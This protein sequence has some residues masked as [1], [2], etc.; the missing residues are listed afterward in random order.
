LAHGKQESAGEVNGKMTTSGKGRFE[1]CERFR[2]ELETVQLPGKERIDR[3]ELLVKMVSEFGTHAQ[4]CRSCLDALDD[5]VVTRNLLLA[6][7][8]ERMVAQPGP[9]FSSRV[10]K[11]IA[12]KENELEQSEGVW[13]SVRRLAPRLAAVSALVLVLAGTWA[14]EV[15]RNDLARQS[16]TAGESLFEATPAAALNDDVLLGVEGH[17]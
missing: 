6:G 9:W 12:A 8:D 11:A 10:M 5:L 16:A 3:K 14:V 13:Q 15:R 4:E 2:E 1:K 7:T 17:R